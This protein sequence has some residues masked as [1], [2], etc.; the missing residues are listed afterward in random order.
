MASTKKSKQK[1]H[2]DNFMAWILQT[3]NFNRVISIDEAQLMQEDFRKVLDD[4]YQSAVSVQTI[5][6][7]EHRKPI[8]CD[9]SE[10]EAKKVEQENEKAILHKGDGYNITFEQWKSARYV[11]FLFT[12]KDNP[13]QN[14]AMIHFNGKQRHQVKFFVH[15]LKNADAKE[16]RP[17]FPEENFTDITA[18]AHHTFSKNSKMGFATDIARFQRPRTCDKDHLTYDDFHK[19]TS[20][21]VDA[22]HKNYE[23]P[24]SVKCIGYKKPKK[25]IIAGMSSQEV[26]AISKYNHDITLYDINFMDMR[27]RNWEDAS[28]V[29]I[30]I[31]PREATR[32]SDNY[33][34]IEFGG[35][36]PQQ[37]TFYIHGK[38]Y[39]QDVPM[40]KVA[41]Y[42]RDSNKDM[43]FADN[44][45]LM[46]RQPPPRPETPFMALLR[47]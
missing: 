7:T 16:Y 22:I 26:Q 5:C 11:E 29:D 34:L 10:Q 42:M 41:H 17:H 30:I 6:Y 35:K 12:D 4:F 27:E 31:T 2:P 45:M 15:G 19:A 46:V 44:S 36:Q 40:N 9:A 24:V 25:T 39:E 38:T 20:D 37:A 3:S 23:G 33:I 32:L 43:G 28:Q 21:C 14:H 47:I 1:D 8:P 13:Q 18:I